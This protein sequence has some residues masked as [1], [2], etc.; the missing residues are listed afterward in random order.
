[1]GSKL[2]DAYVAKKLGW[3]KEHHWKGCDWIK[4]RGH[5]GDRSTNGPP[6]FTTD[7]NLIVGE[8]QARGLRIIID[9]GYGNFAHRRAAV[10]E[11]DLDPSKLDWS[12]LSSEPTLP[13]A[14]CAALIEHIGRGK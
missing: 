12:K 2:T 9:S 13:L 8:I 6:K 11:S 7:L 14:L 3:E 5:T 4:G 10:L 1:M